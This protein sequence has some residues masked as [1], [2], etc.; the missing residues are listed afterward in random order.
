MAP[1]RTGQNYC[2]QEPSS[3]TAPPPLCGASRGL[4]EKL[5][6]QSLPERSKAAVTGQHQPHPADPQGRAEVAT[7]S[8]AITLDH[9]H[10]FTFMENIQEW[11]TR[12]PPPS[13]GH[14]WTPILPSSRRPHGSL[15]S[16]R[17]DWHLT[18]KVSQPPN[19]CNRY[20]PLASVL[21]EL[22]VREKES[23]WRQ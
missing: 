9:M 10:A 20:L 23:S 7:G 13:P 4:R 1:Q 11:P 15:S 17:Q 16:A 2:V 22:E 3:P 8:L 19:P 14:P 6:L 18:S 12:E 5:M 21:T